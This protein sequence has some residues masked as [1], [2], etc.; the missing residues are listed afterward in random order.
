MGECRLARRRGM[1]RSPRSSCGLRS[2]DG[3]SAAT[4]STSACR[5]CST[6]VPALGAS[7]QA[8]QLNGINKL[9]WPSPGGIGV[10]DQFSWT[11]TVT[12]ATG[13]GVITAV[14]PDGSYRTDLAEAAVASLEADGLDTTGTGY[15]PREVTLSPGGE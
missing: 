8:W 15:T 6:T 10:M 5:S 12:V 4:T 14:P 13:Q 1:R 7:H 9:I 3:S 2:A 11:Q